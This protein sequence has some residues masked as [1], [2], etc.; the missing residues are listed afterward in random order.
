[1]KNILMR[2]ILWSLVLVFSAAGICSAQTTLYFPQFVDG[3]ATDGTYWGTII[4]VTN[5]TTIGSA[6]IFGSI[7]LKRDSGAIMELQFTD[8]N[9]QPTDSTF[10]LSG[11]QTKFFYSP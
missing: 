5:P 6:P 1:M 8:E 3:T 10:Q 9:G 11:G 2:N 4:Q 7:T